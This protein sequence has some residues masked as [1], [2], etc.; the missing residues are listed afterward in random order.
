MDVV[1]TEPHQEVAER[2][3]HFPASFDTDSSAGAPAAGERSED[4]GEH[5]FAL[6]DHFDPLTCDLAMAK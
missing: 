5:H 3:S 6:F 4:D 2:P 1:A